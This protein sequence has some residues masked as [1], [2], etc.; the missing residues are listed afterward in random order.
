M[1]QKFIFYIHSEVFKPDNFSDANINDF[2]KNINFVFDVARQIKADVYYTLD[3]VQELKDFFTDLDLNF[4]QS[5]A[6]RLDVLLED[7]I[8]FKGKHHFFKV[9]F[10]G[11]STSFQSVDY[12][13]LNETAKNNSANKIVF[14]KS[15]DTK[16]QLLFVQSS[17]IFHF[18]EINC[19][20]TAAKVWE[21]INAQLPTRNYNFSPKHGNATQ[22]A[23]PPKKGEKVAQLHS[24]D[25]EAQTLLNS[26]I[27]DLREK[28]FYF[29]F[30]TTKETFI[31]FPYEGETPQ[32]QFH[33]FHISKEEW[34]KEVPASV[35]KYFGKSK[36]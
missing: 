9:H 26:A 25:E 32:N 10:A 8:P 13:F 11:D 30:D 4:T 27:F 33:A 16:E 12:H 22:N 28:K 1:E 34:R 18:C 31:I 20:N 14:T 23:N 3:S 2:A 29:N 7:F 36:Y 5:Q 15:L 24:T 21:F 19:F 6:N 17:N 35:L